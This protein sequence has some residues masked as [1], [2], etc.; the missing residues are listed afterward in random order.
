MKIICPKC[1]TKIQIPGIT[2]SEMGKKGGSQSSE[3]KKI[4]ARANA[5]KRWEQYRKEKEHKNKT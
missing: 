5:Q 4:A 3:R 1:K 2:S